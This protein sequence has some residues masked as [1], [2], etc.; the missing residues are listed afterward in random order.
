MIYVDHAIWKKSPN[1]RKTYAH[2]VADSIEELKEFAAKIGVKPHFWH[3]SGRG[4][5]LSH[6]DITSDQHAVAIEHGAVL[7][8]SKQL[9]SKARIM[10]GGIE[11]VV[12]E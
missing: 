12:H 9:L 5:C 7:M 8:D 11:N 6:F 3:K 10:N 2:M 4:G 1:G